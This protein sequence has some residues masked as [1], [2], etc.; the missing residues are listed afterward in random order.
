MKTIFKIGFLLL[1]LGWFI[2]MWIAIWGSN[3]ENTDTRI[4]I[5]LSGFAICIFGGVCFLGLMNNKGYWLKNKEL[6]KLIEDY[7]NSIKLYN[8]AK[9]KLIQKTLKEI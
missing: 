9:E 8:E 2:F 6:D 4:I 3:V 1:E 5:S 7:Q